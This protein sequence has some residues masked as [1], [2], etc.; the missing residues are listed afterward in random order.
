MTTVTIHQPGYL[1]WLGFFDKMAR[2]DVFVLLDDV[3]Y[4][5]NYF[6][7][8]NKIKTATGPI[9][10][11]VPVKVTFGQKLNEV[12][13]ENKLPWRVKHYKSI[14]ASYSRTPYFSEHQEFFKN[15]YTKNW[16]KLID[17][18]ITIIQYL[19]E[20]LGLTTK[21]LRSSE[22]GVTGLKGDRILNICENLKADVYL[23]GQFGRNYLDEI[24]FKEKNIGLIYQEFHHPVYAQ[25]YGE[26]ASAM[27]A[28]DLLFNCGT[29]S[30][31]VLRQETKASTV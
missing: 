2:A 6:D 12:T 31:K 1:P 20:K 23:S 9:W 30:L 22:M 29:E 26:F 13:I 24:K 8:R 3:Q 17:L 15:L 21:L 7:N 10:L 11:T 25:S 28:I 19:A 18:N 5:K 16:E 4:E 14:V 27:A